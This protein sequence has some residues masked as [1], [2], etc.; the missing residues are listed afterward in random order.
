MQELSVAVCKQTFQFVV[1]QGR[2]RE[3]QYSE[4]SS[5]LEK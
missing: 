1:E 5:Y 2:E 3:R 4:Q